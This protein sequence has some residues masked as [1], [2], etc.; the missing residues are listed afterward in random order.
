MTLKLK[1]H[2]PIDI[3]VSR[4]ANSSIKRISPD[5][6][7]A[8]LSIL[9]DEGL[10]RKQGCYI[11]SL[12]AGRGFC[13]WY[14][15]KTTRCFAYEC[16]GAHQMERYNEVL[17]SGRKGSPVMFFVAPEGRK[18]T[19]PKSICDDLEWYLINQAFQENADIANDRKLIAQ[20]S[21]KGVF[22]EGR[23][24]PAGNE[25]QFQLMMGI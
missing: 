24:R 13:P 2:G 3:P 11:F 1:I 20:W 5:N 7:R 19:V 17:F 8:F 4:L 14:I 9:E 6:K 10:D 25:E 21:I 18:K 12:R 22:G 23:G 15:G 16:V